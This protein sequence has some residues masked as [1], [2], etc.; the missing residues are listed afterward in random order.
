MALT[1]TA[2]GKLVEQ[3]HT[4]VTALEQVITWVGA[5]RRD[6]DRAGGKAGSG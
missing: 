3:V 4:S 1:A 6:G 5:D 2:V